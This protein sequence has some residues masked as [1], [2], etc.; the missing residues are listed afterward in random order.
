M[1]SS[2]SRGPTLDDTQWT[3]VQALVGT[4]DDQQLSWLSGFLA[5]IVQGRRGSAAAG[6]GAAAGSGTPAA[7]PAGGAA[8]AA[9]PLTSGIAAPAGRLEATSMTSEPSM[10]DAVT[11]KR[12]GSPNVTTLLTPAGFSPI[13]GGGTPTHPARVDWRTFVWKT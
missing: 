5:G 13:P 2:N 8:P 10:L 11:E 6:A 1:T 12:I 4:L 7:A 9:L 3:Q